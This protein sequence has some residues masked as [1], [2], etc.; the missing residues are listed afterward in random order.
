MLSKLYSLSLKKKKKQI[1]NFWVI[2]YT[3]LEVGTVNG[4]KE[5]QLF[6]KRL[7][8]L[9]IWAITWQETIS[10]ISWDMDI[11]GETGS[12]RVVRFETLPFWDDDSKKDWFVT[13]SFWLL[14]QSDIKTTTHHYSS[15]RN[16][17]GRRR[18]QKNERFEWNKN[19][20][21]G[22]KGMRNSPNIKT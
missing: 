12:Y 6:W 17:K 4:L 22:L 9:I 16:P 20:G 13:L 19:S 3:F 1:R 5:Y 11:R 10:S 15:E 14:P 8:G 7:T 18:R 21:S 2:F